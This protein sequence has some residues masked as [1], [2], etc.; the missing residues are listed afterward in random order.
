MFFAA[1]SAGLTPASRL[2][3]ASLPPGGGGP[4]GGG[5]GPGPRPGG[6]GCAVRASA[7]SSTKM[8]VR[9]FTFSITKARTE[10][11][12][13][14]FVPSCFRGSLFDLVATTDRFL[15]RLDLCSI[16]VVGL[17]IGYLPAFQLSRFEL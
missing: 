14:P 9:T 15:Y 11:P 8:G 2:R 7:V 1:P 17:L 13:A 12:P 4:P 16:A 6:G 3:T 5:A 10:P